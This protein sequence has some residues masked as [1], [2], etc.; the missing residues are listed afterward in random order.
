MRRSLD[1]VG[2]GGRRGPDGPRCW[3]SLAELAGSP[4]FV[5]AVAREFPDH[6]AAWTDP[7]SRRQFLTVMGASL[8]LGGATG[9]NMREPAETLVPYVRKPEQITP[10][11]PLFFATAM[12]LAGSAI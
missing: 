8:A 7:V 4:A 3:H 11:K 12:P 2:D 6:A 1:I 5:D 9:C 10:G